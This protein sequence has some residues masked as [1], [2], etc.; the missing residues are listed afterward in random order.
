MSKYKGRHR[1]K[2]QCRHTRSQHILWRYSCVKY[3]SCEKWREA[4]TRK[5]VQP[6]TPDEFEEAVLDN[7]FSGERTIRPT[8]GITVEEAAEGF[9]KV[10]LGVT[11]SQMP[12]S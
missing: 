6:A 11:M 7:Y 2:C 5:Y 12:K 4:P 3:C 9:R 10:Q 8:G 1:P